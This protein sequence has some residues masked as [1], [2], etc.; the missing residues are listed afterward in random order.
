MD[1]EPLHPCA[2]VYELDEA[3]DQELNE[4]KRPEAG[5]AKPG[6]SGK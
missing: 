6:E 4:W 5:R 3:G 1:D 2:I